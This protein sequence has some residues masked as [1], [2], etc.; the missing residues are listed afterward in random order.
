MAEAA[1]ILC[2]QPK[3]WTI[4]MN[5]KERRLA[6]A[7]ALQS[8]AA[9]ITVVDDIKVPPPFQVLYFQKR[10][11]WPLLNYMPALDSNP[12]ESEHLS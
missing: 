8:A 10:A 1:P 4:K 5:K 6:I 3:D 9:V 11:N 12:G 7:T 2:L